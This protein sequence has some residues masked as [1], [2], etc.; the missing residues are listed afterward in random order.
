M[1]VKEM[2]NSGNKFSFLYYLLISLIILFFFITVSAWIIQ[3]IVLMGGSL[4]ENDIN[5][6]FEIVNYIKDLF[7]KK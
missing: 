4:K 2:Y 3:G 5:L 1:M 6:S 7:I